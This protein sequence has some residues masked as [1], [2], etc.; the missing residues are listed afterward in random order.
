MLKMPIRTR[1]HGFA[2]ICQTGP[3]ANNDRES[4]EFPCSLQT[5]RHP[6]TSRATTN[7]G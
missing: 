4:K 2:A 1:A 7:N 6:Q 3:K 5:A